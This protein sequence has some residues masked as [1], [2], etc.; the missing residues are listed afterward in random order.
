MSLIHSNVTEK[1]CEW[2]GWGSPGGYW[3]CLRRGRGELA[4]M[5]LVPQPD[6]EFGSIEV[7]FNKNIT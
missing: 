6:D 3:G 5:D 2:C 1:S 4:N 7:H